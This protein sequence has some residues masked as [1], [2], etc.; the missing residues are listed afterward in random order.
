MRKP[1]SADEFRRREKRLIRREKRN[2]LS[3]NRKRSRNETAIE[4]KVKLA[5]CIKA[6]K[7]DKLKARPE[8]K[9]PGP[10]KFL[11][12]FT[13]IGY[14]PYDKRRLAPHS[15]RCRSFNEQRQYLDFFREFIYP[16]KIPNVLFWAAFEKET[17]IDERERL[18]PSPDAETI[19]CA[20]K[21]IRE[22]VSGESFYRQNK[23]F[24]TRAEAHFFLNSDIA[25]NNPASVTELIFYAKCLARK[26]GVKQSRLIAKTFT[27]K[28]SKYWN[29]PIVL[30]F[31]DL[32]ARSQDYAIE[33]GGFDDICDFVFSEITKHRKARSLQPPFSFSGRTMM[34]LIALANEWHAG[35]LRA[36]EAQRAVNQIRQGVNWQRVNRQTGP[37]KELNSSCWKGIS[38]HCSN[39][40][41]E[42]S[43]WA[44]TQ[45]CDVRALLNEGRLMKNCV[46]SYSFKCASGESAIFHA[47]RV[48]KE[49]QIYMDIATLEVSR[50][51]VLAQAKGKC[52]AALSPIA[53]K[54]IKKWAQLNRIKAD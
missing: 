8:D 17:I 37:I 6:L 1:E 24:F 10:G 53:I 21:W 45:L 18:I 51:R 29:H 40:E 16:Y 22:I 28:F 36:E 27:R 4:Q 39:V 30:G 35:I 14:T 5:E 48:F 33:N 41:D 9:R 31:L 15:Y 47:S 49:D 50:D 3:A 34:S 13:Y 38:V 7:Q 25:Y 20:K 52:N 2:G 46:S 12:A 26:I 11:S 42:G 23:N 32:L 19:L 44:F 43:V 54:V